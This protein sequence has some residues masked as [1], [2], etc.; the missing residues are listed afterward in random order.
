MDFK[1]FIDYF[2]KGVI[3]VEES[4]VCAFQRFAK[5]YIGTVVVVNAKVD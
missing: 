3:V 4:A 1:I 5:S 2:S